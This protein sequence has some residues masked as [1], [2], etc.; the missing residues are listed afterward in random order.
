MLS[1]AFP[2]ISSFGRVGNRGDKGVQIQAFS[3]SEY[4]QQEGSLCPVRDQQIAQDNQMAIVGIETAGN[5][6]F[7]AYRTQGEDVK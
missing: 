5:G 1:R 2:Q 3:M 7:R 6:A 4:Q